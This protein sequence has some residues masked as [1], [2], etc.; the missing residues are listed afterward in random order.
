CIYMIGWVPSLPRKMYASNFKKPTTICCRIKSLKFPLKSYKTKVLFA[1]ADVDFI[2][3]L[4]TFLTLPMAMIVI[5]LKRL[6]PPN[7]IGSLTTLY[8][9]LANLDSINFWKEG[10]KEML[11]NPKNVEQSHKPVERFFCENEDCSWKYVRLLHI[12]MYYDIVTCICGEIMKRSEDEEEE[13]EVDSQVADDGVFTK[14]TSSFIISDDLQIFPN[15][16]GFTRTLTN[17]G[18]T[19]LDFGE[20][21]HIMDL[22]KRCL[23]SRTPLSDIILNKGQVNDFAGLKFE[24][25]ILFHEMEK[26]ASSNSK[27]MISRVHIQKSTNKVLFAQAEEDFVDL[28]CSFLTINLGGIECLLGSNTCLKSID[29]LYTSIADIIDDKNLVSAHIRNRLLM[30]PKHLPDDYISKTPFLPISEKRSFSSDYYIRR[31][32]TVI[33]SSLKYLKC[34][35]KYIRGPTMYKVTD[36]LTVTPFCMLST[37]SFFEE[38]KISL[39]DVKELEL[40]IRLEEIEID[41]LDAGFKHIEGLSYIYFCSKPMA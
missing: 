2:D 19:D 32:G 34:K 41:I 10:C 38:H 8:D 15:T 11:L 7:A 36:D 4:V 40:E 21:R 12:N 16:T 31:W 9:G 33:F 23:V 28:L 29:N 17:L 1:E 5:I 18:I 20:Q 30:K 27:K 39:S 24:P 26:E 14:S 22:L 3:I 35:G 25:G 37:L 6:E 13:D